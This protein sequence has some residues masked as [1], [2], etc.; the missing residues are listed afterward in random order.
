MPRS[1][2]D[3]SRD[4]RTVAWRQAS[5]DEFSLP[6]TGRRPYLEVSI[7]H[8]SLEPTRFGRR[9]F[10]NAVEYR[11]DGE[12]RMWC[13]R[14]AVRGVLDPGQGVCAVGA[15]LEPLVVGRPFSCVHDADHG[16]EIAVT[17]APAGES[18]TT[19]V[20]GYDAP[21]IRVETLTEARVDLSTPVGTVSVQPGDREV[22]RLPARTVEVLDGESGGERTIEPRLTVR[23]PGVVRFLHPDGRYGLF[24]SFGLDLDDLPDPVYAPVAAGVLDDAALAHD[25]DVDLDARPYGERPLWQAFAHVTFDPF[26]GHTPTI[27][28][29]PNGHFL[30]RTDW[31][32]R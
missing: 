30:V 2:L 12:T 22:V 1:T 11:V 20:G 3:G 7:E 15:D 13:W 26:A 23:Y 16:D 6:L 19:V 4:R 8:P 28:Q 31:T 5:V 10:P 24:P 14:S 29:S 32:N 25:L 21:T 18:M 17:A 9:F 27:A